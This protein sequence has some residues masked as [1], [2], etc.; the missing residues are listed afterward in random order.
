MDATCYGSATSAGTLN[1]RDGSPQA[2]D[3]SQ[4]T[5]W[6]QSTHKALDLQE[7]MSTTPSPKIPGLASFLQYIRHVFDGDMLDKQL[8][9]S[10]TRRRRFKRLDLQVC[11]HCREAKRLD[12]VEHLDIEKPHFVR[13]CASCHTLWD[14]DVN[15][16]RNMISAL[17]SPS[18]TA[19]SPTS[20]SVP[21][22]LGDPQ[23]APVDVSALSIEPYPKALSFI[24]SWLLNVLAPNSVTSINDGKTTFAYVENMS[25][26]LNASMAFGVDKKYSFRALD[27]V[28]GK[29]CESMVQFLLALAVAAESKN[30]ALFDW[31][32]ESSA[33]RSLLSQLEAKHHTERTESQAETNPIQRIYAKLDTLEAHNNK[34]SGFSDSL[35]SKSH[36]RSNTVKHRTSAEM[37][38][39]VLPKSPEEFQTAIDSIA[40]RLGD[41]ITQQSDIIEKILECSRNRSH[42]FGLSSTDVDTDDT[43]PEEGSRSRSHQRE[44][45]SE[46]FFDQNKAAAPQTPSTPKLFAKLPAEVMNAG[47]PKPEL[48]RL[49]VVYE[50]IETELDYVRDLSVMINI[51]RKEAVAKQILTEEEVVQIFS[52]IEDLL[53]ANQK[54]VD[55]LVAKRDGNPIIEEVGDAFQESSEGLKVYQ[56]YCG[57]YPSAMRL[58]SE[59]AKS[60]PEFKECLQQWMSNPECRGLSLESFLIKPVQR[61]CKYPLLIKELQRHTPKTSKDSGSLAVAMEKIEA[62]VTLVNEATRLLGEKERILTLQSKIDGA[63]EPLQLEGKKLLRDGPVFKIMEAV[64]KGHK[65]VFHVGVVGDKKDVMSF[66]CLLEDDRNKWIDAFSEGI[67]LAEESSRR[68]DKRGSIDGSKRSSNAFARTP[69]LKRSLSR[70]QSGSLFKSKWGGSKTKRTTM[71]FDPNESSEAEMNPIAIASAMY[72]ETVEIQG[73]IWKRTFAATLQVYYYNLQTRDVIW[74]LPEGHKVLDQKTESPGDKTASVDPEISENPDGDD[75]EPEEDDDDEFIETE[76][77]EHAPDWRKVDRDGCVYYYNQLT[78]EVSWDI[79]PHAANEAHI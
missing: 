72:P 8:Y 58:V 73:Q 41:L 39:L 63:G 9:F 34:L 28:Q 3:T 5:K 64:P 57:N 56:S 51:H 67:K 17:G 4:A 31:A 55:L 33:P 75:E 53:P 43:G 38:S 2:N 1:S 15:A 6:I 20:A 36:S 11:S 71:D 21:R 18:S 49:S 37:G 23:S 54:L 78:M 70:A 40:H 60:R 50:L 10:L 26:F 61:I 45:S 77:V 22:N 52:N 65:F 12:K 62:V 32:G 13:S 19:P 7:W 76:V 74:K 44:S 14:R 48:M 29:N 59:I 66:S 27:F 42:S 69:S 68:A 35:G 16:A 25:S 46:P 47:L 30:M 79:P 24:A